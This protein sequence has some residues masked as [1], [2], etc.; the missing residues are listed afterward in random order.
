MKQTFDEWWESSLEDGTFITDDG[1]FQ[2][3]YFA[4]K[5]AWEY[6]DVELHRVIT[7][8]ENYPSC[9]SCYITQD[10]MRAGNNMK[11]NLIRILKEG[12]L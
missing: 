4:A 5:E 12:L 2:E 7:R 10:E 3:K 1:C 6:K 9:M 11:D 8:L